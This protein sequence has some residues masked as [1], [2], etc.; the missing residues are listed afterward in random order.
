MAKDKKVRQQLKVAGKDGLTKE[1]VKTIAKETGKSTAQVNKQLNK[2][3]KNLKD[4]GKEPINTDFKINGVKSQL[5]D[6]AEGG[7]SKSELLSITESTGKSTAQ[8][9]K[10]LDKLNE[11]LKKQD[12][13]GVALNSGAA[14]Q[15]VK[16]LGVGIGKATPQM[17]GYQQPDFGGGKIGQTIQSMLGTPAYNAQRNVNDSAI[18]GIGSKPAVPAT[19]M[20]GGT[21]IKPGGRLAVQP[22][23]VTTVAAEPTATT[24]DDSTE[25]VANPNQEMVNRIAD[26]ENALKDK[27]SAVSAALEQF[28]L[29]Y[30]QNLLDMSNMFNM[31][32][33]QQQDAYNA[34]V[35]QQNA[36]A[37][38]EQEAA[39]ALMINQ[40]RAAVSPNLQLG[41]GYNTPQ[42]TGTQGFKGTSLGRRVPP[43]LNTSFTGP[44][45][46][47]LPTATSTQT[48]PSVLNV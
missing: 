31:Q 33:A 27:D 18:P 17:F 32:I 4:K 3:N 5:R 13:K 20:M 45:L 7:I 48:A 44:L 6:A 35:A 12:Q 2:V 36:L 29:N 22:Q 26:L 39:R 1:E 10:Q 21:Q 15:I 25:L 40:G 30:D 46:T 41:F 38:Q 47:G 9:V 23:P 24:P 37:L 42:L 16:Q 19:L 8:V 11:N 14:N 34:A 28:Q 43:L